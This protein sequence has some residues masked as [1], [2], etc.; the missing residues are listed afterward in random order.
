MSLRFNCAMIDPQ[1]KK[2]NEMC[3]R[4]KF[5]MFGFFYGFPLHFEFFSVEPN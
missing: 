2:I 4:R 1:K 3:K 5:S